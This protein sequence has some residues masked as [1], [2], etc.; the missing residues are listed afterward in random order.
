[1]SLLKTVKN[2][3]QTP[4]EIK[5]KDATN[6][7]ENSGATGSLMNEL[8][9][10]TFSPR[11]LREITQVI[12][13]RLSGNY[14]KSSHTNA[15]HILKTLTLVSYLL[16]NGSNDF[17]AW[18]RSYSYLIDTLRE[19]SVNSRGRETMAAQIRNL[20][21]SLSELLRDDELL[22]QHRSDVTLF[23]SSISTPGRKST[24]NSHLRV[25]PGNS[26]SAGVVPRAGGGG[27][28]RSLDLNQPPVSS[29]LKNAIESINPSKAVLGPLR[30]EDSLYKE[31]PATS[32][33]D[34]CKWD[35]ETVAYRRNG[36]TRRSS[37]RVIT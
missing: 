33:Y 36:V 27:R 37:N 28:T 5:I 32:S 20:A 25:S 31:N 11:T 26:G 15:V 12:K 1:M 24:D 14:R 29:P 16:N 19:F 4:T 9:V 2:L 22:K 13:K 8:S 10:L 18:V 3:G 34:M 23:R 7:D 6:D 35:D 21:S 30:E 17:V